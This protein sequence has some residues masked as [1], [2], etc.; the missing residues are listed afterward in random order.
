MEPGS[1]FFL[2]AKESSK[3]SF[4]H[5]LDEVPNTDRVGADTDPDGKMQELLNKRKVVEMNPST[6]HLASTLPVVMET[7]LYPEAGTII[8]EKGDKSNGLYFVKKG[9]FECVDDAGTVVRELEEGDLFGE[10]GIF[11][12]ESR[13]LTVRSATS[14]ASLWFVAKDGYNLISQ[15]HGVADVAD[16]T[17]K[18]QG[19]YENYMDFRSKRIAVQ[20]F[21]AFRKKLTKD[22]IDRVAQRLIRLSFEKGQTVAKQG[23]KMATTDMFFIDS[24]T[25]EVYDD[26]TGKVLKTYNSANQ[27][28][29]E[30]SFFLDRPRAKSIRASSSGT[31]L[32]LS[33]GNFFDVVDEDI[34]EDEFLSL[35]ANQYRDAGLLDK[36]A[37][38]LDYLEAKSRPKKKPV[39]LHSTVAIVASGS[40]L[41]AYQPFF[42]PGFDKDGFVRFFDFSQPFSIEICHQIQFSVGLMAVAGI[43]GYFRI[44]PSAPDARRLTFTLATLANIFFAL[45]MSSS[46]N[47]LPEGY[48]L[49][50]AFSDGGTAVI[51]L[52][53][54]IET[55]FMIA[56]F[57]NAI[58]GSDA[59]MDSIPGGMERASNICF[60]SLIYFAVTTGQVA[61]VAPI[62][63]SDLASYQGSMSTAFEAVSLPALNFHSFA[64]AVGFVSFL[65]LLAT[66]QFKK[67]IS[68]IGGLLGLVALFVVFNCDAVVAFCKIV[69]LPDLLPTIANSNNYLP[70]MMAQNHLVELGLGIT[71]LVVLNA[72]RKSIMMDEAALKKSKDF[73]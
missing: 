37:Q 3:Q 69:L 17:S 11:L 67:K 49:F 16:M 19:N 32:A 31:L 54:L 14:G 48:W 12:T 9:V 66:L 18:L 20:S 36:T 2:I 55:Y 35:L 26:D 73:R 27:Y 7:E 61:L 46:L 45:T 25:F 33:R 51:G 50:D 21:N 38:V 39:S 10:I 1:R 56:A 13:A 43:M 68:E 8:F 4:K 28:F 15:L 5:N 53:Y 29:G 41:S 72:I 52:S 60:A 23:T 47:A 24:G 44:P 42:H 58:S 34:F 63:F 64:T 22:E 65:Q 6:S 40:Y 59:G 62:F 57:D 70:N 71:G 30:L